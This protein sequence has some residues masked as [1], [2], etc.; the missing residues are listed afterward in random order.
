MCFSTYPGT[1]RASG[2]LIVLPLTP[3]FCLGLEFVLSYLLVFSAF[4]TPIHVLETEKKLGRHYLL[5]FLK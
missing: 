2:N 5:R 4:S 1:S 3:A